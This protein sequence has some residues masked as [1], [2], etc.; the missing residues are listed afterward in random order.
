MRKSIFQTETIYAFSTTMAPGT[1]LVDYADVTFGSR[2]A[3]FWMLPGIVILSKEKLSPK[4]AEKLKKA[5]T[6]L[7]N[8]VVE[9]FQKYKPDLVFVDVSKYKGY[10]ENIQFDYIAY[11]SKDPRFKKIWSHYR[12]VNHIGRYAIY[13]RE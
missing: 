5:K 13:Q 10:F 2:F 12:R 1:T 6:L 4:E 7:N 9:D 11:F 8:I 3:D